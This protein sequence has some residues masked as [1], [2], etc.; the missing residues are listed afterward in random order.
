M[1]GHTFYGFAHGAAGI[2]CALLAAG[3]AF[4]RATWVE[5]AVE[6]GEALSRAAL[7][8]GDAAWWPRW[9]GQTLRMLHWCNG[10]AGVGT[11]LIRLWQTTGTPRYRDLAEMAGVA[12]HRARF[13]QSASQCHGLAGAAPCR[14]AAVPG[15]PRRDRPD[16]G[17]S[18]ANGVQSGFFALRTRTSTPTRLASS[19]LASA[20]TRGACSAWARIT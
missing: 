13:G 3:L 2:G 8:D 6:A 10:S 20:V 12:V 7:V 16:P 9:P 15:T 19:S 1:A 4:E 11:F 5:A 17:R 14:A 18:A